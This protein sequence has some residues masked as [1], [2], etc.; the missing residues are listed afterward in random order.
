M[1]D[2]SGAKVFSVLIQ[3]WSNPFKQRYQA[4]YRA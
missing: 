2:I 1:L 4:K 3:F